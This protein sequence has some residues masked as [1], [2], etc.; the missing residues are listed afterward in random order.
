MTKTVANVIVFTILAFL[1]L[2]FVLFADLLVSLIFPEHGPKLF[3]L[4]GELL[5]PSSRG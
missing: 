1:V 4:L 2:C 5:N 3:M